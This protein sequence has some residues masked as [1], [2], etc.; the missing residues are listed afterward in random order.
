MIEIVDSC[1]KSEH[2]DDGKKIQVHV[3]SRHISRRVAY[4]HSALYISPSMVTAS[5][6][7]SSVSMKRAEVDVRRPIYLI[8]RATT[9]S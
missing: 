1:N 3:V 2:R 4:S 6:P 8:D 9:P 7:Y 5:T